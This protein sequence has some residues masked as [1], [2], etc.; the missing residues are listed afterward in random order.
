MTDVLNNLIVIPSLRGLLLSLLLL[1]KVGDL[2]GRGLITVF[3][4]Y[5]DGRQTHDDDGCLEQRAIGENR[6]RFHDNME[7]AEGP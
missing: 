3:V 6:R 2:R 1:L 7:S 4:F 5:G